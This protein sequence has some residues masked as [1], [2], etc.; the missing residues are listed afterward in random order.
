NGSQDAF[1]IKIDKHYG[2]SDHVTYMQHGIP[3]V[4]FI[5]WP[6][7]WYHSSQDTPDKQDSTQYRRAA[8]VGTGALAVI[9]TGTDDLAG[10][11]TSENLGRGTERIG[12]SERKGVSYLADAATADALHQAWKDARVSIKHQVE[13]E[14]AVIRSGA[15]LYQDPAGAGKRLAAL[16]AAVDK[17][18]AALV[19]EARAAYALHAQ[20][21]N[22]APVFDPPMTAE[23]KD[24]ANLLVQC[25]NGET[26]SGCAP[27]PGAG[28]GGPGG[29]GGRGAGGGRGQAA[30]PQLPQHMNAEL[31]ILLGKKMTALEIRDFLS[32][33]FEPVPLSDV[34]AVL[35]AREAGGAIKLVPKPAEPVK[36]K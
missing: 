15:V 32:G 25:V 33:E 5:T 13:V 35:R 31:T 20:R 27:A 28:R 23:E 24:A 29:A 30:G 6:D 8:I 11:V 9:A 10:R 4:M 16:E 21:F 34:M 3:A 19:D 12:D 7:M 18:G 36:K 17:K 22:V 1:Y 2:S 26:F 14:K